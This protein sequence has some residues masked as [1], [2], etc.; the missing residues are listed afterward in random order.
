LIFEQLPC[1]FAYLDGASKLELQIVERFRMQNV[2]LCGYFGRVAFV[3]R[4]TPQR[5]NAFE[6]LSSARFHDYATPGLNVSAAEALKDL[7]FRGFIGFI[8]A[9]GHAVSSDRNIFGFNRDFVGN[10]RYFHDNNAQ[11]PGRA[12]EAQ[13]GAGGCCMRS[14]DRARTSHV[15]TPKHVIVGVRSVGPKLCDVVGLDPVV[16]FGE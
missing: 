15:D 9:R 16:A 11:S 5:C 13:C 7:V 12:C 14:A 3:E 1:A 10:V 6:A 8:V 2:L 4:A